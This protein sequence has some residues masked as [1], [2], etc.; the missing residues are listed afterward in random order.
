MAGRWRCRDGIRSVGLTG[1]CQSAGP[2]KTCRCCHLELSRG[3]GI[4]ARAIRVGIA[5]R[6]RRLSKDQ[7]RLLL[8]RDAV[9]SISFLEAAARGD[10]HVA[11][12]S[13]RG[14]RHCRA[15]RWLQCKRA[16][17]LLARSPGEPPRLCEL[18]HTGARAVEANSTQRPSIA[19]GTMGGIT[20][21]N[22]NFAPAETFRGT[23]IFRQAND[24]AYA[25][26]TS[27]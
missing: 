8:S 3:R 11:L 7:G 18:F 1:H 13:D 26:E 2:R 12:K 24:L 5:A 21:M 16:T 4:V 19:D 10:R 15:S 6:V 25:Y 27:H 23:Q 14:K 17:P 22:L 20:D 9:D